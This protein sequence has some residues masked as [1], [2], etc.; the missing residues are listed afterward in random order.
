MANELATGK[1]RVQTWPTLDQHKRLAWVPATTA[2][3]ERATLPSQR[4]GSHGHRCT[5]PLPHCCLGACRSGGLVMHD[6]APLLRSTW[7]ACFPPLAALGEL[8]AHV[9]GLPNRTICFIGDSLSHDRWTAALCGALRLG[10]EL[11]SCQN[12][13]G[14]SYI[15]GDRMDGPCPHSHWNI[16]ELRERGHGYAHLARGDQQ[17]WL[18]FYHNHCLVLNGTLNFDVAIVNY[19][20][21]A[22]TRAQLARGLRC[23][24]HLVKHPPTHTQ[25]L[26]A[27]TLPQHFHTPGGSFG[28]SEL[29]NRSRT[30]CA[31]I[32]SYHAA[33][34]RN[35][36]AASLFG[37]WRGGARPM[38]VLR[39]FDAMY[40]RWDLHAGAGDCTHFCFS[41][42]AHDAA[43]AL[44]RDALAL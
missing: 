30:S 4:D 37:S 38:P 20:A 41:P 44:I 43:F 33:N 8:L 39:L 1:S 34:W 17:L 32:R 12:A 40:E 13:A 23:L 7:A 19:G 25:I 21:W 36:E 26:W 14:A 9:S 28:S 18:R 15:V 16:A 3:L 6:K 22:N 11:Q 10:W 2:E 35:A 29:H 27:E 5:H 24:E 42:F 31:P